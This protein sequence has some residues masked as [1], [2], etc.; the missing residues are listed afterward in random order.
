MPSQGSGETSTGK[1]YNW[2][3][4]GFGQ[5]R[6]GRWYSDRAPS[7]ATMAAHTADPNWAFVVKI[8][9]QDGTTRYVT[10]HGGY[11]PD[12]L[13]DIIDLILEDYG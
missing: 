10:V 1:E 11:D 7:D 6:G 3:I 12:T 13:P 2:S 8:E 9:Y 4:D 5:L